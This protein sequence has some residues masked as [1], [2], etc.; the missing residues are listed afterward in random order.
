MHHR[1]ENENEPKVMSVPKGLKTLVSHLMGCGGVHQHHDKQHQVPRGACPGLVV[2]R[3][4]WNKAKGFQSPEIDIMCHD[5]NTGEDE[6][7]ICGHLVDEDIFVHR[8]Q[9]IQKRT[10]DQSKGV[11][12]EWH[13]NEGTVEAKNKASSTGHPHRETQDVKVVKFSVIHLRGPS[14]GE[15]TKVEGTPDDVEQDSAWRPISH[16]DRSR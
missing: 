10:A 8:N 2:N 7:A 1:Q 6:H 3:V 4:G 14:L 9:F 11:P 16:F 15:E 12:A 5:M 13:K